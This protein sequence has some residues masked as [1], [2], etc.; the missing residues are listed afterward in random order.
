MPDIHS[1]FPPSSAERHLNCTASLLLEAQCPNGQKVG[2]R[3]GT[4]AHW[5]A[6]NKIAK[7]LN[8]EPDTGEPDRL[9]EWDADEMDHLTDN[10]TDYVMS[11]SFLIGGEKIIP[12]HRVSF[13]K[14]VDGGFGT[15]DCIIIGSDTISII[16]FKYGKTE[17]RIDNNVQLKIYALGAVQEFGSPAITKVRMHIFQPRIDNIGCFE[18]TVADL[19]SW[20]DTFVRPRAE[21]ALSGKESSFEKGPWCKYCKARAICGKKNKEVLEVLKTI[22]RTEPLTDEKIAE[23]LPIIDDIAD[24]VSVVKE[25]ATAKA[26]NGKEWPGMTLKAGRS[27]RVYTDEKAVE[28]KAEKLNVDIHETKILTPAALE[29]KVGKNVY[30][31]EFSNFVKTEPGKPTLVKEK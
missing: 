12:E 31:E 14:W 5:V 24:W 18:M 17:V 4:Y 21:A 9:P 22:D 26:V 27:K 28:E 2:T 20:A 10:Y 7:T 3:E 15:S 19:V 30:T 16:D 8:L 13:N 23:Y 25:Y 6:S 29:K 11:E 1:N